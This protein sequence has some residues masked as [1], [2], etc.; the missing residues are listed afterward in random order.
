MA[1]FWFLT[2]VVIV[3]IL[4]AFKIIHLSC[5]FQLSNFV[6]S[7]LFEL[8]QLD[9][10]SFP[11]Q[12][13][14]NADVKRVKHGQRKVDNLLML[15]HYSWIGK[16]VTFWEWLTRAGW[17]R[18]IQV[19]DAWNRKTGG[20]NSLYALNFVYIFTLNTQ[21]LSKI[22]KF[23]AVVPLYFWSWIRT[24]VRNQQYQWWSRSWRSS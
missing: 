11:C 7:P 9:L 12:L 16:N 1:F 15:K 6:F 10:S 20:W 19:A 5:Y 3:C 13:L 4:I 22:T 8:F 14:T 21:K 23:Y 24:K 17:N 2:A 18:Y